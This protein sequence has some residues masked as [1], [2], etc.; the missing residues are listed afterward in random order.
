MILS[1]MPCMPSFQ[2]KTPSFAI[3]HTI[4]FPPCPTFHL[5]PSHLST[6]TR[7][8]TVFHSS[9]YST[10]GSP[11]MY[12]VELAE[13]GRITTRHITHSPNQ[14]QLLEAHQSH[15]LS[16]HQTLST[17]L[18]QPDPPPQ[19][20]SPPP[21]LLSVVKIPQSSI[22]SRTASIH[23][24]HLINSQCPLALSDQNPPS[25]AFL[26]ALNALFMQLG[27]KTLSISVVVY[28]LGTN[29]PS[30]VHTSTLY[31]YSTMSS[32]RNSIENG[33]TT[34]YINLR[35]SPFPFLFFVSFLV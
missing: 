25:K 33:K 16:T 29:I 13:R 19:P 12:L 3:R 11:S 24:H 34:T 20:N 35:T 8:R 18:A 31:V 30:C 32:V 10:S 27:F 2:E 21:Q 17:P 14:T 9:S 1:R 5:P 22:P 26:L 23:T 28:I 7:S 15:L 4:S 6:R